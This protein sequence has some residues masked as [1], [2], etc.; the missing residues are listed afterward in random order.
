MAGFIHDIGKLSIPTEIL[1]KPSKLTNIEFSLIKEHSLSGYEMLKDVESPWPLAEI[2]YQHHER[3][4]GS[5]YPRNLKGM[6]FSWR[7]AFWLLPMWWSPWLPIVLIVLPWVLMQL[8]KKSR[9]IKAFFMT[10]LLQMPA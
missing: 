8:L 7:R 2:I 1:S 6:K 4:N 10:M 9:K 3:M 5:G